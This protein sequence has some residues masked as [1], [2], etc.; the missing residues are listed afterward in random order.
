MSRWGT[1]AAVCDRRKRMRCIVAAVCDYFSPAGKVAFECIAPLIFLRRSQ[2]AA[3]FRPCE[4]TV[5][6]IGR[7]AAVHVD[8]GMLLGGGIGIPRAIRLRRRVRWAR[9]QVRKEPAGRD[10]TKRRM[11]FVVQ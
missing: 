1:V 7:Y 4:S 10:H 6:G 5:V 3:T 8:S 11:G 9:S 2:S